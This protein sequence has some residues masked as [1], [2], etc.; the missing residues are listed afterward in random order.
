MPAS[1]PSPSAPVKTWRTVKVCADE[2]AT[3]PSVSTTPNA[4]TNKREYTF[5]CALMTI[6]K[7]EG[8]KGALGSREDGSIHPPPNAMIV[9]PMQGYALVSVPEDRSTVVNRRFHLNPRPRAE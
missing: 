4:I 1:G 7:S 8:L 5:L 6:K 3:I 2:V 9:T